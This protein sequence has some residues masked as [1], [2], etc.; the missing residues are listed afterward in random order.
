MGFED[1]LH[2]HVR[3]EPIRPFQDGNGRVVD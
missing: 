3:F 2:F 1:S